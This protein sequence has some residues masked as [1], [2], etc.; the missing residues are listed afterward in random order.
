[1]MRAVGLSVVCLG[2]LVGSF[3]ACGGGGDGPPLD[4]LEGGTR[5]TP[6]GSRPPSDDFDDDGTNGS[7]P[8]S[9]D[10]GYPCETTLECPPDQVCIDLV[11][12]APGS[13][14]SSG[15]GGG[16]SGNP[17]G[18]GLG[19][20]CAADSDCASDLCTPTKQTG[21]FACS[22]Q[23]T[24]RQDNYEFNNPD[25]ETN[26]PQLLP[27]CGNEKDLDGVDRPFT[28]CRHEI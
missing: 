10:N 1:M 21:E 18:K 13:S 16:S 12:Q 15:D 2:L 9:G 7:V 3:A 6:P 19:A 24:Y 11:C 4:D 27:L 8:S 14:S 17:G 23:C 28:I 5:N 26:C 22:K 25:D 20:A